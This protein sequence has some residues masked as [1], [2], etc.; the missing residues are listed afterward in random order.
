M[1][2]LW[3]VQSR[4]KPTLA[5]E[6]HVLGVIPQKHRLRRKRSSKLMHIEINHT[7]PDDCH[8][9]GNLFAPKILFKTIATKT[10]VID[11][12]AMEKHYSSN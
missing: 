8:E 1:R 11:A 5:L 9:N 3:D 2:K 6:G 10:A 12:A 7:N 4:G